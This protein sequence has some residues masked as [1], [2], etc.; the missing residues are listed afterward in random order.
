M[1]LSGCPDPED[2]TVPPGAGVSE[3]SPCQISDQARQLVYEVVLAFV[4]AAMVDCK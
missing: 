1:L 4:L 2:R 3:L